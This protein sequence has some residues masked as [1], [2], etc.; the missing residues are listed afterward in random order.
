VNGRLPEKL[1]LRIW[2]LL[3]LA[4][5]LAG[6]MFL[7]LLWQVG[8]AEL[9][10]YF[11]GLTGAVLF[12]ALVLLARYVA[13]LEPFAHSARETRSRL[14]SQTKELARARARL[15][16]RERKL[17]K[18]ILETERDRHERAT[19]DPLTGVYNRAH[20]DTLLGEVLPRNLEKQRGVALIVID[21]DGF[22]FLNDTYGHDAGDLALCAVA[23]KLAFN[24]RREAAV[25]RLADDEFAVLVQNVDEAGMRDIAGAIHAD[26][27]DITLSLPGAEVQLQCSIGAALAP[28]HGA[29]ATELARAADVALYHAKRSG[30]NRVEIL[31]REMGA[32]ITDLF[33][34]GFELRQALSAGLIAPFLQP[35]V[36]LETGQPFAYEV[37]M[38][39]RRQDHYVPADEFI[40]VA[41]DLGLIREMDLF[42]MEQVLSRA[43]H[44]V[45]LFI[46]LSLN[47]FQAPEFRR[48]LEELLKSAGA[49]RRQIVFEFT[50]RQT[51]AMNEDF[52]ALLASVRE[53]GCKIALDDF[54]VGYSSFGYVQKFRPEFIKIDG[55]FVQRMLDSAEDAHIVRHI[56]ELCATFGAV[57]VAEHVESEP[58]RAALRDL[59]I[60]LGQ[61]YLFSHPRHV[62]HYDWAASV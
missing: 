61:G 52:M 41:E 30:R 40:I 58:T 36:S 60:S 34:Q 19:I 11:L 25:A 9:V 29:S 45:R 47:S 8:G 13:P 48:R 21:L 27:G 56:A 17:Q 42:V 55:S 5:V 14:R 37:L 50:E 2:G 59:G 1:H 46:N 53:C 15:E 31:T 6:G 20:F 18:V 10:P 7:V 22:K 35:I 57:A 26:I 38:R 51:T 33:S 49:A 3:A 32:A 43:P 4:Q 24:K 39:L 44:D 12:V 62:E 54:G 23:D 28:Q 16:S